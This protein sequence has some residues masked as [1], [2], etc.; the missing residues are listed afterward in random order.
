[1]PFIVRGGSL[2]V[3]VHSAA[4]AVNAFDKFV[5]DGTEAKVEDLRR[6][7]PVQIERL[8]EIVRERH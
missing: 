8:R 4:E 2:T 5:A 7:M 3:V 1:M 6:G